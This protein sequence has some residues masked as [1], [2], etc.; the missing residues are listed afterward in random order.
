MGLRKFEHILRFK[1]FILRTDSQCM[2]FLDS[3]KEV[4]GIYARWLTFIQGFEFEV[5]HRP[6]IKN[7][8]ADPLSRMEGLVGTEA[9]TTVEEQKDMEEDVYQ[10]ERG[11]RVTPKG[12]DEVRRWQR[13]DPVLQVVMQWVEKGE[14]PKKVE[15]KDMAAEYRAYGGV[16]E[17]LKMDPDGGLTFEYPGA[18]TPWL[19]VPA[20][21]YPA[22]FKWAHAHPTAGHFGMNAT[23]KRIRER[24]FLPGMAMKIVNSISNCIHPY[25]SGT[26]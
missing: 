6:G 24:F 9:D 12:R 7:Q 16:F 21:A 26:T 10:I 4:R 2:Q 20:D 1:P 22:L 14:K 5:V 18:T 19:C 13:S 8:N 23:Q 15:L 17:Q 11:E 3:L 25:K